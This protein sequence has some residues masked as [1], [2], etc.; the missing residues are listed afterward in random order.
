M[1]NEVDETAGMCSAS[2]W[3]AA[4]TPSRSMKMETFFQGYKIKLESK[5]RHP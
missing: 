5:W 1:P 3:E 2:G 4:R